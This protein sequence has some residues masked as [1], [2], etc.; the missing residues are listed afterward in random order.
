MQGREEPSEPQQPQNGPLQAGRQ[1]AAP[2]KKDT[3]SG[4]DSPGTSTSSSTLSD[5][6]KM[7]KMVEGSTDRPSVEERL[8][9]FRAQL[10]QRKKSAPTKEKTKVRPKQR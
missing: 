8:K 6:E 2:P 9:G 10:D 3:R 5:A 1:E 4:R 7:R